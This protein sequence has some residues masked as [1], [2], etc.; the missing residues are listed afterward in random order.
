[1]SLSSEPDPGNPTPEYDESQSYLAR[2]NAEYEAQVRRCREAEREV[3]DLI[4]R[5]VIAVGPIRHIGGDFPGDFYVH[6][7]QN[8]LG[9]VYGN[10]PDRK[11]SR[12]GKRRIGN[13]LRTAVYERDDYACVVCGVRRNLSCDHI[14][15][16]SQ[17]G[18]TTFENLQ[19]MCR[20]CNIRKG[21]K[22]L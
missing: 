17:G 2:E 11:P 8:R 10:G 20:P 16:E 12:P 18:P 6:E 4:E 15:P 14:V 5:F 9:E 21:V 19:T 7:L 1:M 3:A 13:S 22:L